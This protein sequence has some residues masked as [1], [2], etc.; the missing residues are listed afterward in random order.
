MDN[1]KRYGAEFLGT[2]LLVFFG[3]GS[4]IAARVEGGVVVVALAFGFT[5]LV[6]T[7]MLVAI[8]GCHVNPAVTLGAL[9]TGRISLAGAIGYWI[10]QLVG[11][12]IGALLLWIL[13]EGG[14]VVDQS[15]AL[16]TNGYGA[17]INLGG[18]F[19]LEIVLTF[20]LVLVVLTV[21]SRF[22]Q[23]AIAGVAVGLA[24]AA[25]HLVG[26]ALDGTSVNPARSFGP[27]LFEGGAA[28]SQLWVFIVAPLIGGILAAL[29]LPF[30]L[31][32]DWRTPAPGPSPAPGAPGEPPS[33]A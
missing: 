19:L 5:L 8:S 13:V 25:C 20:L 29:A 17:N 24:I 23:R 22:E 14:D 4:V 9:L 28:L 7:Y 12:V 31:G 3:V 6:L 27:A 16:G 10:S 21:T 2:M 18:T 30:V 33:V 11:S 1:T 26:V 15:G 32:P